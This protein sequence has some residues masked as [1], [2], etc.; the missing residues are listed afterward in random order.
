MPVLLD[1]NPASRLIIV[2]VIFTLIVFIVVLSIV[3]YNKSRY[4]PQKTIYVDITGKKDIKDSNDALDYYIVTYGK[5]SILE[6]I[7]VIDAW[8]KKN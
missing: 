6:H 5:Q 3:L 1:T 2:L 7:E 8:K 4:Y